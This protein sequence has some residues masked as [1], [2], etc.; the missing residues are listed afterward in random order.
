MP[1]KD[2]AIL[3]AKDIRHMPTLVAVVVFG[4]LLLFI[5]DVPVEVR[6]FFI[7]SLAI[8]IIGSFNISYIHCT[9]GNRKAME[10]GAKK[11]PHVGIKKTHYV[12]IV[13]AH[14]IWFLAFIIYNNIKGVL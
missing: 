3:F 9:L 14:I 11:E 1:E 5:H 7:P 2:P 13:S 10:K 4:L 6:R 8:Y 12:G